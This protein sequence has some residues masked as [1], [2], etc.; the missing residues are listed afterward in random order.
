MRPKGGALVFATAIFFDGKVRERYKKGTEE[1]GG[2][3]V[4]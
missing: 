1:R 2:A 3:M 4:M